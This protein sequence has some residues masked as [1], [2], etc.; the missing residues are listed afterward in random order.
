[1]SNNTGRRRKNSI[2]S[3]G[4]YLMLVEMGFDASVSLQAAS[5]Y[6]NDVERAVNYCTGLYGPVSS[7]S[8]ISESNS[9]DSE[10]SSASI[11]NNYNITETP[12]YYQPGSYFAKCYDIL[13]QK[14]P[15]FVGVFNEWFK[16]EEF[17][18]N[19]L[20]DEFIEN[21]EYEESFFM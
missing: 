3:S 18:D 12:I 13:Q 4:T 21:E 2:E 14:Y 17:E 8:I 1:M 20:L 7:R 9:S 19:Q 11:D 16:E 10:T 5:I 6:L 15:Q